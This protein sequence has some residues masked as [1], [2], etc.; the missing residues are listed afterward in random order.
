VVLAQNLP[1][2]EPSLGTGYPYGKL[3]FDAAGNLYG[4][5]LEGGSPPGNG[6]VYELSPAQGGGWNE[7]ILHDFGNGT[8]GGFPF[9]GVIFDKFGNLYGTTYQAGDYGRG[10]VFEMTPNGSGGWIEKKLKCRGSSIF[11]RTSQP[12]R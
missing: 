2:A 4:T 9:S 3:I 10:M 12:T 5:T 11:F 8:D 1:S 6:T 7:K